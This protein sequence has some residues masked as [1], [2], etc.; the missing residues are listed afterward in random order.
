MP[1]R[2]IILTFPIA[3]AAAA[4]PN[5]L[6]R[7][8]PLVCPGSALACFLG[9]GAVECGVGELVWTILYSECAGRRAGYCGVGFGGL[10]DATKKVMLV[11]Y[12]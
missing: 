2:S 7:R 10:F 1:Q 11:Q 5:P 8:L 6:P 12:H 9:P 3:S 4:I